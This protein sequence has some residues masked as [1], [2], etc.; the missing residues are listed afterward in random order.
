MSP[1]YKFSLSLSLWGEVRVNLK[2][3]MAVPLK[4][5]DRVLQREAS[6]RHMGTQEKPQP[7]WRY[8]KWRVGGYSIVALFS[9]S[10]DRYLFRIIDW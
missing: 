2:L 5:P 7:Q 10:L 3:G 6:H 1:V 8:Y 9:F 4:I